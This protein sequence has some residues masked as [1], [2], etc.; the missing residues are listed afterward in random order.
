[1]T[2][3]FGRRSPPERPN[4]S[5]T[6]RNYNSSFE[7]SKA[8]NKIKDKD[9]Y[10]DSECLKERII[11][12]KRMKNVKTFYERPRKQP[13][14]HFARK[15]LASA[16]FFNPGIN[17]MCS[18]F[19]INNKCFNRLK[20][21][22]ANF[23]KSIQCQNLKFLRDIQNKDSNPETDEKRIFV[24]SSQ[25]VT[26]R[27]VNNK[28]AKTVDNNNINKKI[29]SVNKTNKFNIYFSISALIL[30]VIC[31]R[32]SRFAGSNLMSLICCFLLLGFGCRVMANGGQS[33]T[34]FS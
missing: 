17:S 8:P 15:K 20:N 24:N 27:H 19:L 12:V 5:K 11:D 28:C 34:Y 6:V 22:C 21:I 29:K 9:Y 10:Q 2:R 13:K 16:S 31:G 14:K 30:S 32:R 25:T 23:I 3:L 4:G 7:P 33:H 26:R 18:S 1:M